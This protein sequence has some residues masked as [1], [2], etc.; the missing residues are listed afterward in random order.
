MLWMVKASELKCHKKQLVLKCYLTRTSRNQK[1][2]DAGP[3]NLDTGYSL[4]PASRIEYPGSDVICISSMG[5]IDF[6]RYHQVLW[7]LKLKQQ[8]YQF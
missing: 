5:T 2:L 4:N 7:F 6:S 3:W 8:I 1:R